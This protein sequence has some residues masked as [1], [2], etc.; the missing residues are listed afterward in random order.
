ML[1]KAS[2]T[3]AMRSCAR[4]FRTPGKVTQ[5][6]REDS[7]TR[8]VNYDENFSLSSPSPVSNTNTVSPVRFGNQEVLSPSHPSIA[9]RGRNPEPFDA[10]IDG[11]L[12]VNRHS[13]SYFSE[14]IGLEAVSGEVADVN[15]RERMNFASNSVL[16]KTP[17]FV[18]LRLSP[19]NTANKL[20]SV[21]APATR[22]EGLM[23][24]SKWLASRHGISE[25][26]EGRVSEVQ[27]YSDY[28]KNSE[29]ETMNFL[30]G[31]ISLGLD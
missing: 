2:V 6:V 25:V 1:P 7:I 27:V 9:K 21:F 18:G 22:A 20:N 3:D 12:A 13:T 10:T 19:A 8:D 11:S 24:S 5:T 26:A 29:F 15:G 23:D 16:R 14:V 17:K 31:K 28:I 4:I 30:S